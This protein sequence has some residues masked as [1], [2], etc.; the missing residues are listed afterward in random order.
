MGAIR[1]QDVL[2]GV[3]H[4]YYRQPPTENHA[5]RLNFYNL[6]ALIGGMNDCT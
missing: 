4:E 2:G 5:H 1:R 6:Q 3:T